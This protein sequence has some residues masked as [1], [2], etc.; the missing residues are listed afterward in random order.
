MRV[1]W[2]LKTKPAIKV[3]EVRRIRQE[4]SLI[5]NRLWTERMRLLPCKLRTLIKLA[6]RSMCSTT[7]RS[8]K[9][10]KTRTKTRTNLW[11]D[12]TV[13]K[14]QVLMLPLSST[15]MTNHQQFNSMAAKMTASI[16]CNK[17]SSFNLNNRLRKLKDMKL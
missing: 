9:Y 1:I 5:N 13:N 7:T 11:K 15:T 14:L 2:G 8:T 10:L 17:S 12:D 16:T 6:S 4:N 3:M